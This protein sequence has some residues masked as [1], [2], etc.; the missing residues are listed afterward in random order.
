MNNT[1]QNCSCVA[2]FHL[3]LV[4]NT[5]QELDDNL[6]WSTVLGSL[7]HLSFCLQFNWNTT[8]SVQC[9]HFQ[10]SNSEIVPTASIYL[11]ESRFEPAKNIDSIWMGSDRAFPL[12][13]RPWIGATLSALKGLD[14]HSGIFDL[15]PLNTRALCHIA[16]CFSMSPHFP[17]R[18]AMPHWRLLFKNGKFKAFLAGWY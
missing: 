6:N 3:L 13:T 15:F 7:H 16:N 4:S 9:N 11:A 12:R 14:V 1:S 17:K 18:L 2:D 10:L 5:G 8:E